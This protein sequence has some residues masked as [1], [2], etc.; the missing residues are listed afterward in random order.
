MSRKANPTN[1]RDMVSFITDIGLQQ[2]LI[3]AHAPGLKINWS[4]MPTKNDERATLIVARMAAFA[5]TGEDEQGQVASLL[6]NLNTISLINS[7]D[8]NK[9]VILNEIR[10]LEHSK[11]NHCFIN[12][13]H[14]LKQGVSNLAT[15]VNIIANCRNDPEATEDEKAAVDDART[16]WKDLVL[17]AGNLLKDI[18]HCPFVS[19]EP[20]QYDEE[21][22]RDGI[23]D[24]EKEFK[25][26]VG[27]KYLEGDFFAFTMK[28]K[29][30]EYVRYIVTTAPLS[31]QVAVVNKDRK[32]DADGNLIAETA[33]RT[34]R[35]THVKTFEIIHD[36]FHHRLCCSKTPLLAAKDIILMFAQ[37]VFG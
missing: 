18:A 22:I 27:S 31:H 5:E 13:P 15:F 4:Q 24:F 16:I 12:W 21:K 33:T 14:S 23:R 35:D 1:L 20:T 17:S 19:F 25:A 26:T 32:R 11:L 28:Y 2:R 36:P 34:E 6:A 7:D 37:C 30:N 9:A 29:V 10:S 8:G 3:R